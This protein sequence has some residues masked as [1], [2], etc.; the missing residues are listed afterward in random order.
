[1]KLD[2]FA[3]RV[4]FYALS[5]LFVGFSSSPKARFRGS[6]FLQ[7]LFA[8][9]AFLLRPHLKQAKSA[10]EKH[11]NC[12]TPNVPQKILASKTRFQRQK[13]EPPDRKSRAVPQL[14]K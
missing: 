5:L 10:L 9:L 1:S 11:K 3:K 8:C 6:L 7:A 12:C 2:C 13:R 14:S 4:R